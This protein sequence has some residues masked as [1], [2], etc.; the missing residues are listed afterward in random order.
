MMRLLRRRLLIPAAF[1][2]AAG[3][4]AGERPFGPGEKMT[5]EVR[6]GG[7]KAGSAWSEVQASEGGGLRLVSGCRSAP[8]YE[9]VYMVDDRVESL[10]R[11]E[12][13]GSARYTTR[14]REGRFRQDQVLDFGEGEV[15]IWRKQEKEG[16]WEESRDT[17][18]LR[19][20]PMEDPQT[21][22]YRLRTLPLEP[23]RTFRFWL[24]SG[25]R[26]LEIEARVGAAE[27]LEGPEGSVPAFPIHVRAFHRGRIDTSKELLLYVS[28][29]ARRLPLRLRLRIPLGSIY[30]DLVSY[31]PPTPIASPDPS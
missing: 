24:F 25:R 1:L 22:L 11:G 27:D 3:V 9:R 19:G 14:F 10:W 13:L 7:V 2:W 15:H 30:V 29:D 21:A 18:T 4:D 12:G 23:G 31:S 26:N 17:R 20:S 6:F 16:I 8:W 28:A 5:W